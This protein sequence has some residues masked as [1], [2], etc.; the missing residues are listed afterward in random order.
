MWNLKADILSYKHDQ[1]N[2]EENHSS[3]CS[4]GFYALSTASQKKKSLFADVTE[5]GL[6]LE[7]SGVS[8]SSCTIAWYLEFSG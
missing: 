7:G 5:K 4:L 1:E 6:L 8:G 2:L 3:W